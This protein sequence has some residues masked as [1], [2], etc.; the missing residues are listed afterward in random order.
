MGQ[1]KAQYK[2]QKHCEHATGRFFWRALLSVKLDE[3]ASKKVKALE[4]VNKEIINRIT[5]K[6]STSI[7]HYTYHIKQTHS[8]E[9]V[10]TFLV[11][12]IQIKVG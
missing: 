4:L 9:G 7:T 8:R 10:P 3:S 12:S 11:V 2:D 1:V 5:Q 6:K